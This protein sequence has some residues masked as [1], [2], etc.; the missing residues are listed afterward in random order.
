[1]NDPHGIRLLPPQNKK[2]SLREFDNICLVCSQMYLSHTLLP[3]TT[4]HVETAAAIQNMAPKSKKTRHWARKETL[5]LKSVLG[6]LRFQRHF[7]EMIHNHKKFGNKYLSRCVRNVQPSSQHLATQRSTVNKSTI[8]RALSTTT[9]N[10][11]N[12]QYCPYF[13][14]ID[15]AL[16]KSIFLLHIC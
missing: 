14:E 12:P 6:E 3:P 2:I 4:T 8:D 1:M 13:K 5:Y 15:A 11:S 7:E 16:S 9:T 10:C